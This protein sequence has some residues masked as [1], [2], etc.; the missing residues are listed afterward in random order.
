MII[1]A[2]SQLLML[3]SSTT[4][5]DQIYLR[6]GHW[7]KRRRVKENTPQDFYQSY[8]KIEAYSDLDIKQCFAEPQL[9]P[10]R[11]WMEIVVWTVILIAQLEFCRTHLLNL[12]NKNQSDYGSLSCTTNIG[13]WCQPV[14]STTKKAYKVWTF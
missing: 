4:C 5:L 10:F 7:L 3:V 2:K 9:L 8:T 12:R 1:W 11:G 13:D 14:I 6:E